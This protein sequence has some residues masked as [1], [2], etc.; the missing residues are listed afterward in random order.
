VL[1]STLTI[2]DRASSRRLADPLIPNGSDQSVKATSTTWLFAIL[3]LYV[4]IEDAREKASWCEN[5]DAR[6]RKRIKR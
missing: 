5:N 2:E 6:G 3:D 1:K 4:W